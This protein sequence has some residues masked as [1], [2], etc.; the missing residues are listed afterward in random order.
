MFCEYSKLLSL[1]LT[2]P[3][4]TATAERPFSVMNRIKTYLRCIMSQQRLNHVIIPHIHKE[5]LDLL[6][7]NSICSDFIS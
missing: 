6:D 7:L 4:T 3:V 1:Y 5:K 2:I